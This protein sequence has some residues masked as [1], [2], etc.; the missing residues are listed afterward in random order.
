MMNGARPLCASNGAVRADTWHNRIRFADARM[1]CPGETAH[2][3]VR[4]PELG[5]RSPV[6]QGVEVLQRRPAG[7][8]VADDVSQPHGYTLARDA[9]HR[10]EPWTDADA[11]LKTEQLISC[12]ATRVPA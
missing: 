11:G 4:H 8:C 12:Y 6:A 10:I 1:E 9:C 2:R 5:K 3:G 7:Q